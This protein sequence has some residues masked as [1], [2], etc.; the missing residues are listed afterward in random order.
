MKKR[1]IALLTGVAMGTSLC[2]SGAYAAGWL[3]GSSKVSGIGISTEVSRLAAPEFAVDENFS[4]GFTEEADSSYTLYV[5]GE[6][7]GIVEP[8]NSL[9]PALGLK[10]SAEV[11]LRRNSTT[12]AAWWNETSRTLNAYDGKSV[13]ANAVTASANESGTHVQQYAYGSDVRG[14]KLTARTE[15]T[16][17]RFKESIPLNGTLVDFSTSNFNGSSQIYLVHVRFVDKN[18]E[19][20]VFELSYYLDGNSVNTNGVYLGWRYGEQSAGFVADETGAGAAHILLANLSDNVEGPYGKNTLRS[21][22]ISFSN[23][24]FVLGNSYGGGADGWG[25]E[26]LESEKFDLT[27]FGSEGIY[28]ELAVMGMRDAE[29]VSLVVRQVGNSGSIIENQSFSYGD[30]TVVT[31]TKYT[32]T[33]S[34]TVRRIAESVPFAG[35]LISFGY[36]NNGGDFSIQKLKILF[37]DISTQQILELNFYLDPNAR[38]YDCVYA[39][40]VF[41]ESSQTM[42]LLGIDLSDKG[43]KVHG[44]PLP[45]V[46]TISYTDQSIRFNNGFPNAGWQLQFPT[47]PDLGAFGTD[48]VAVDIVFDTLTKEST[49]AG[50]ESSI[51]VSKVGV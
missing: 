31:G 51:I 12:S 9:V 16:V 36:C 27:G 18:D 41:G 14:V 13:L 20:K 26:L 8:G 45:R 34:G 3:L 5:D 37:T 22:R 19:S 15:G 38:D 48:G 10:P 44:A 17:F 30:D 42:Q 49:D 23:G 29:N 25:N 35:N 40:W 47:A 32:A 7:K 1:M 2:V 50:M 28:V 21:S 11:T 24:K 4:L 43:S 6:K 33:V 39:G 46:M